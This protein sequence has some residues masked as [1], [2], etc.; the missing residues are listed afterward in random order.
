MHIEQIIKFKLRESGRPGRTCAPTRVV[1]GST[2][3]GPNPAW[4]RKLIWSRDVA[5]GEQGS[6]WSL[7]FYF[8]TLKNFSLTSFLSNFM[9]FV[10]QPVILP[11]PSKD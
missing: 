4:T 1:N 5:R 10:P 8:A 2:N 6:N 11:P 9:H 7:K 3:S